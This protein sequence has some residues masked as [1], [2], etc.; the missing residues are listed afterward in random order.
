MVNKKRARNL[1]SKST[2]EV[3]RN[4]DTGKKKVDL[5]AR[6]RNEE[7]PL[8]IIQSSQSENDEKTGQP[9]NQKL[10]NQL[11]SVVNQS[12]QLMVNQSEQSMVNHSTNEKMYRSRR[13]RKLK[14]LRLPVQKLEKWQLWCFMNKL[15]FQDAV[16]AAMD[17]LTSQPV[18]HVLIDDLDEDKETDEIIIFYQKWT[19]NKIKPKDRNARDEVKRFSADICKIGILTA[20]L[21]AK[22]KINSFKYCVPV[23]EEI[24]ATQDEQQMTDKDRYVEYLQQ[25][26]MNVRKVG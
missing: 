12:E 26:V 8:D 9:V 18:N 22:T 3:S 10:V 4:R 11:T 16:E 7:H 5:F 21:R 15:D 14:G 1:P 2:I 24:A 13:E 6:L 17:W 25:T 20:I 23:I 19:G